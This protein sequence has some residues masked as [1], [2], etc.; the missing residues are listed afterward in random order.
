HL[1]CN[2]KWLNLGGGHQLTNDN[3][4]SE[5]FITTIKN[6]QAK[7][8]HL[9]LYFEPGESVVKNTGYFQTTIVDI[10]PS[11]PPIIMLDTS[12]EAHLLDI[13]I[14]KQKP[15]IRN[16][17]EHKTPYHYQIV[18]KSCLAGDLMGEY[19]FEE[20]LF[21][22]DKIVFEDMMGY[23]MVKQTEFNGI[24]RAGFGVV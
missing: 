2:L 8:P 19:Y 10:I 7:Y 18:G 5:A 24:D 9:G 14:T 6:F 22:A 23:T 21:V 4:D 12:I 13:A 17:V 20:A 3:Y 1:L 15:T 11:S 16:S